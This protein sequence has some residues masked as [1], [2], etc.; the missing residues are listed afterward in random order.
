MLL[1]VKNAKSLTTEQDLNEIIEDENISSINTTDSSIAFVLNKQRFAHETFKNPT[2]LH[3][4][5]TPETMIVEFSSPNIA[6]PFHLGH[7]RSTIIGNFLS[8]LLIRTNNRVIKMNYLG[9]Y[10]T[11]FGFL[12][13]GIELENLTAEQIKSRPL[14]CL[15]KAYVTANNSPDPTVADRAR[16][17]FEMMENSES[18]ELLRQWEDIKSYTMDELKVMYERLN[19]VYDV[20]EFESMY[21][22]KEISNVIAQLEEKNLLIKEDGKMVVQVG[23]RRVPIVKSDSTTLYLTRDIAAF[24]QRKKRYEMDKIFYVVDNGQHDHFMAIKSIVRDL[25][26]EA[27]EIIH[28]VKFGRIHGMS[29]RKGSVVFLKDI[30]DEA[31]D[32]M[33]KKQQE[34]KTTKVDLSHCGE[35]IAEILGSS[36]VVVNDLKQRRQR[37]YEFDWNKVL[38]VSGDTGVK[39]Q[40]THCRLFNLNELCGVTEADEIDLTLLQEPAAQRLVLEILRYPE[41]IHNC[42]ETLEACGLVNY[43]FGLR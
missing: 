31:K 19:V 4:S 34:S 15:F 35:T 23:D 3:T 9:D 28:H 42:A 22:R 1:P 40:Y 38:Q 43:L 26:F 27:D 37:D 6:K 32:L 16:K 10:G 11:Q 29:T 30:L 14:K 8:N 25:G 7:L 36:A 13:V 2:N 17:V 18:K 41:V 39:L 24:L 12:K 5:A 33:V 20:F 21:R